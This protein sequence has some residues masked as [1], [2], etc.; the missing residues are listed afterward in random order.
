MRSK[1]YHKISRKT[2]ENVDNKNKLNRLGVY[3]RNTARSSN[4]EGVKA[5]M[6][7]KKQVIP[8]NGEDQW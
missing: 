1:M 2:V 4:Y 5:F 6:F 8:N 3:R 7:S